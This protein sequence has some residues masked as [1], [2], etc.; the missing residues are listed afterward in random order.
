MTDNEIMQAL[1]H[2]Y[3][4]GRQ[5]TNC[6][7]T[8]NIDCVQLEKYALDL[9]NRQKAEKEALIAGQETLQKALAEKN[10]EIERFKKIETTVNGFWSEMQKLSTF[11][12]KRNPTLEELL[13]YMDNLKAEAIKEFAERLKE[14]FSGVS[15]CNN[16][17][18]NSTLDNIVKEMV[19]DVE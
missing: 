19:G 16:G 15:L 1:E 4:S 2:C 6:P 10:A 7:C 14:K 17:F 8:N 18:V 9:I 11:K 13:E 3:A 12:K 5:C